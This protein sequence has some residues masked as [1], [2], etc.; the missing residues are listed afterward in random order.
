MVVKLRFTLNES[1]QRIIS[2]KLNEKQLL[3]NESLN[4]HIQILGMKDSGIEIPKKDCIEIIERFLS[5]ERYSI[6]SSL[7]KEY[8]ASKKNS[9][10]FR[11]EVKKF[12]EELTTNETK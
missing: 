5:F 12:K 8:F 4:I 11:N 2:M 7:G 10:S 3:P 6:F 1:I 9:A